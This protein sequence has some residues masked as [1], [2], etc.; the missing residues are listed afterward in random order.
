MMADTASAMPSVGETRT[1][2]QATRV[3][4]VQGAQ[5]CGIPPRR[6]DS[7]NIGSPALLVKPSQ[8]GPRRLGSAV[9]AVPERCG[10]ANRP[11]RVRREAQW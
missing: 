9:R 5:P 4:R 3:R 7:L 10:P 2:A 6:I 8:G 1:R 11:C